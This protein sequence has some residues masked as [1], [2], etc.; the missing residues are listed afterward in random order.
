MEKYRE[1]SYKGSYK[2]SRKSTIAMV[3][4]KQRQM[5]KYYK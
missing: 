3:K 1:D 2:A 5:M 4:R